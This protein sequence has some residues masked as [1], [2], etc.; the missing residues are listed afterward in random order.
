MTRPQR[1]RKTA[2]HG[3]PTIDKLLRSFLTSRESRGRGA[4]AARSAVELLRDYLNG[5]AYQ[6]LPP[7]EQARWEQLYD[8]EGTG[9]REYCQLFGP[10]RIGPELGQFFG[11]FLIREVMAPPGVLRDVARGTGRLMTWLAEQ[12]HLSTDEGAAG[13]ASAAEAARLVPRA[14]EAVTLINR[15]LE[16][17][18]PQ[19]TEDASEGYFS[20]TRV[21]RGKI[22]LESLEEGGRFGPLAVPVSV[23]DRIECGWELSGAVGRAGRRR[24]LLEVWNIYPAIGGGGAE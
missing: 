12:G 8:Q 18:P 2:P 21:E 16:A 5:Y 13:A 10:E 20:V 9:H 6:S 24:V 3:E 23:T 11:W 17:H 7:D 4:G 1:I 14:E 19:A 22:W 15:H